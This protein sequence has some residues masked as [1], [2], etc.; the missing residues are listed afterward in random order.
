M[1]SEF[2]FAAEAWPNGFFYRGAVTWNSLPPM[3]YE[4]KTLSHFKST[5]KQLCC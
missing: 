1:S 5:F 2:F 4:A 3:L